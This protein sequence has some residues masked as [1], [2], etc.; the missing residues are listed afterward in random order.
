MSPYGDVDTTL[1]TV[2]DQLERGPYVLGERYTAAD[3]LWASALGWTTGFGLIEATPA[4]AAYMARVDARPGVMRAK[5][6]DRELLATQR[7]V[8]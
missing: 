5:A 6:K 1:K 2:P 4:I 3:V 7:P 8:G